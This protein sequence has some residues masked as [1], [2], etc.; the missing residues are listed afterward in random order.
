MQVAAAILCDHAS[1]REGL[2]IVVGGGI[3]RLGRNT[4]P[5]PLNLGLALLLELHQVELARPHE[6]EVLIQD[7]DGGEVARIRGGFN[8][9]EADLHLGES[10]LVPMAFDLRGVGIS[11]PGPYAVEISV[12]GTHHRSLAFRVNATE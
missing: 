12:D 10:L 3:T 2:L 9:G 11:G 5:A 4:F 8:V 6:L 1:V 7:Q